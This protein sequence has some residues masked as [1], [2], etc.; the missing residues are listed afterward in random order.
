MFEARF[1]PDGGCEQLI[2]DTINAADFNINALL[3]MYQSG[4][5]HTAMLAA[6]VRGATVE[7]IFD[8]RQQF[9]VD[10]RIQELVAAGATCYW[11]KHEKSV[12]SQYLFTDMGVLLT[13]SYIWCY[14]SEIRYAENLIATDDPSLTPLFSDDF[15]IHRAHSELITL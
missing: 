14:T 5:I 8:R 10:L 13:G 7:L 1:S 11:D 9:L 15:E 6:V 12:R 2:I 4:P 3:F